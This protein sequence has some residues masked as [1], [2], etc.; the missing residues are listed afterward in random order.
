MPQSAAKHEV[1]STKPEPIKARVIAAKLMGK[2]NRAIAKEEGIH[3]RTVQHI[4]NDTQ[5]RELVKAHRG[6]ILDLIPGSLVVYKK[7]LEAVEELPLSVA[8]RR[9]SPEEA[10]KVGVAAGLDSLKAATEVL[11]GTQ[12]FAGKEELQITTPQEAAMSMTDDELLA[13]A[14]ELLNEVGEIDVAG[15]PAVAGEI[16]V[17][18]HVV[19]E[20]VGGEKVAPVVSLVE[21][22][23]V[24]ESLGHQY[25]HAVVPKLI[26][27]NDGES[28]E[29]LAESDAVGNDAA[30]QT[31]QL[32]DGPDDA[33]PLELEELLPDG[34]DTDA[35][36]GFDDTLF[37]QFVT[38]VFENVEEG[39]VIDERRGFR[40][41]EFLKTGEECG[42]LLIGGWQSIPAAREPRAKD[43]GFLGFL[44]TLDQTELIAG[45]DAQTLRCESTVAGD[46]TMKL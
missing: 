4:L 31:L 33:V 26:V 45:S 36:G 15:S 13:R 37:V 44:G 12:A 7:A 29:G 39:Q 43:G 23:I 32:V 9:A 22:P 14:R 20:A 2:S 28:L 1:K 19:I 40:I 6:A 11:K 24:A 30:A 46:D 17:V 25:Q 21:C 35:R 27:F 41:G 5:Y 16:G 3:Q 10:Y 42:F 8:R 34:G 38:E 18:E